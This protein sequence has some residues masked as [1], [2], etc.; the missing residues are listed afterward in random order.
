[1]DKKKVKLFAVPFLVWFLG[2]SIIFVDVMSAKSKL[3]SG[4]R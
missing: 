1:M 3:K 4:M 2:S